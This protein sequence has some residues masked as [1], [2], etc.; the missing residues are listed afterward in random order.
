MNIDFDYLEEMYD[1]EPRV[2]MIRKN[3]QHDENQE[4]KGKKDYNDARRI[5]YGQ[6][7]D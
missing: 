2:Q 1:E 6:E 7:R 5:K 4:R 3:K